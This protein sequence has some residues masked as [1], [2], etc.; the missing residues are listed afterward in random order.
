ME[1]IKMKTP[2]VEMDGDEMTRVLWGWIK[3]ILICP[4]VDLKTEYYDLGLVERDKTDDKVTIDSANATKKYGVAVKCATITPNAQRVEEYSL[5]KMYKS[6]NGTIRA[7]LDGTVFRAPILTSGI[8]PYMT[9]ISPRLRSAIIHDFGSIAQFKKEF[10]AAATSLF[11]SGWVW[12][13]EDKS[14]KLSIVTTQNADTPIRQGL[15]PLL[16]LDVW[17]HAY[18]IDYRNRRADFIR[19]WWDIVDWQ[20]VD[21]KMK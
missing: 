17:E 14:G 8:T 13:V 9:E 21:K 3:E 4:F 20:K 6:P 16:V 12:L 11:G 2:L 7:M 5:K 15:T 18:Y 19:Q 1:K 10:T